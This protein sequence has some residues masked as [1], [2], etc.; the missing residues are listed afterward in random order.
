MSDHVADRMAGE[1]GTDH[2]PS[3]SSNRPRGNDPLVARRGQID[4]EPAAQTVHYG[5]IQRGRDVVGG[6][7]GGGG[8]PLA[9]GVISTDADHAPASADAPDETPQTSARSRFGPV[10][11]GMA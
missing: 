5:W 9:A 8:G 2:R 1:L 10:W 4:G 3:W 7:G 6:L 11:V